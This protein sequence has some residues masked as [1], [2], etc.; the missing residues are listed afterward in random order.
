MTGVFVNYLNA[1]LVDEIDTKFLVRA[2]NWY[3][4]VI[5]TDNRLG[6]CSFVLLEVMQKVRYCS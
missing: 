3:Q 4:K 2:W 6:A 5:A 1:A